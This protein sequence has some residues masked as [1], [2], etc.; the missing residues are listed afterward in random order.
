MEIRTLESVG[1]QTVE[2]GIKTA[3]QKIKTVEENAEEALLNSTIGEEENDDSVAGKRKSGRSGSNSW[4][5]TIYRGRSMRKFSEKRKEQIKREADRKVETKMIL[6]RKGSESAAAKGGMMAAGAKTGSMQAAG[7][8]VKA[9]SG[10]SLSGAMGGAAKSTAKGAASGAA[11][12][13]GTAA[14]GAATGGIIIG[15][16][17]V[18]KGIEMKRREARR[19]KA[20]LETSTDM[21]QN[22]RTE[23]TGKRKGKKKKDSDNSF[24]SAEVKSGLSIFFLVK[25]CATFMI[26]AGGFAAV[27]A[28]CK[29]KQEED[30]S[31]QIVTVAEQE[32]ESSD[33]NIGGDKYKKWYGMDDNWCAMFVSWCADQC[34][35]IKDGTMPRTASVANM[36]QWYMKADLYQK[37]ESG[38]EPKAGDII[39]FGNGKSHTGIVVDYDKENQIVIT[40][41]GNTGTSFAKP[42]H[43]GSQVKKCKYPLNYKYTVGYGTPEYPAEEDSTET[44]EG[45]ADAAGDST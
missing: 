3:K 42:Y 44:A 30:K 15:V 24:G 27:A 29:P 11:K 2:S 33:L 26:I 34:G 20:N 19:I 41:E 22:K 8:G 28:S 7:T 36:A 17:A 13:G 14:A 18:K 12:A 35:Y 21:K 9:G 37:K 23:V 1:I 38:Y 40:I 10:S 6:A 45:E 39:F 43:K 31:L 32:L 5:D 16:A 25:L 4:T